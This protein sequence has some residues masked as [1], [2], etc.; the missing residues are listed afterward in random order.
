MAGRNG[1]EDLAVEVEAARIEEALPVCQVLR[2]GGHVL[3][4][5]GHGQLRAQS[6]VG[7]GCEAMVQAVLG[8]A[9]RVSKGLMVS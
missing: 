8:W 1:G 7:M 3:R 4:R 9:C 2:H 6:V 5:Q